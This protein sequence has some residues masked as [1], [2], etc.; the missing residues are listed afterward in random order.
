MA[1]LRPLRRRKHPLT[2]R[3]CPR[4]ATGRV[5]EAVIVDLYFAAH[6][7]LTPE[8]IAAQGRVL[9]GGDAL[10]EGCSNACSY[11]PLTTDDE[12][13]HEARESAREAAMWP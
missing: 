9:K 7:T 6:F 4:P 8:S 1:M 13:E 10:C 2:C 12:M 11:I 3:L 5:F